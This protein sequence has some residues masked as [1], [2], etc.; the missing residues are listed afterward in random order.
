MFSFLRSARFWFAG[1]IALFVAIFF[2]ATL[3]LW[4][5]K[6]NAGI[7]HLVLPIIFFPLIWSVF[8]FY[9]VMADNK[10]RMMLVLLSLLV[11]CG[12]VVVAAFLGYLTV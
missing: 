2:M 12:G 9:A 6:G 11:L 7:N 1:P 10:K 8:F 4:L 5:P 3:S